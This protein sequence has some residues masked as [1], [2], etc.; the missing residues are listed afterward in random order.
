MQTQNA[1]HQ[2]YLIV[3]RPLYRRIGDALA[4]V[5]H[6]GALESNLALASLQFDHLRWS[7]ASLRLTVVCAIRS[8]AGATERLSLGGMHG[9]ATLALH[10]WCVF[11][12]RT[13][14]T[15]RGLPPRIGSQ[16]A[17]LIPVV[18]GRREDRYRHGWSLFNFRFTYTVRSS[19]L[20]D[21]R[22]SQLPV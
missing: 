10:G 18:F 4:V 6:A 8:W 13:R 15:S 2:M 22:S 19:E 14:T 16:L 5:C 9:V 12:T 21:G 11:R 20:Q 17:V 3:L 7:H 1:I